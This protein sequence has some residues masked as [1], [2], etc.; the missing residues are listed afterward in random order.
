M[1]PLP[2]ERHL[3][4]DAFFADLRIVAAALKKRAA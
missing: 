4:M 3:A 2:E 1:P